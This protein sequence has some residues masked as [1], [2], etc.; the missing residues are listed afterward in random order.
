[1]KVLFSVIA[2]LTV[3]VGSAL[4]QQ[5][6][7][8]SGEVFNWFLLQNKEVQND[9]GISD[10]VSSKLDALQVDSQAALEKE[11]RNAGINP[12]NP[13]Q[14]WKR[15]EQKLLEIGKKHSDEFGPKGKELLSADQY[16]RFRQIDLQYSLNISVQK[17]LLTPDVASELKLTDDQKQKLESQFSEYT[18]SRP[19]IS[20]SGGL[21]RYHKLSEEHRD[22]YR[23]KGINVLTADQKEILNKM[24]GS[25]FDYSKFSPSF[26]GKKA[27][28][29]SN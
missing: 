22:E 12:R 3:T 23:T 1:M 19:T 4:A 6:G 18:Q 11:Y 13:V 26:D 9:L 27:L 24:K 15:D 29:S 14:D 25:E 28:K 2:L 17:A 8:T 10:D 20:S 16:K 21:V 5:K 7:M